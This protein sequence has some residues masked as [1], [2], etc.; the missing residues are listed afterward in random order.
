MPKAHHSKLVSFSI[1]NRN[2]LLPLIFCSK[3]CKELDKMGFETVWYSR[4]R[5]YGQGSRQ[6][7]ACSNRHGLIRKYNLN[8]RYHSRFFVRVG[9]ET[10]YASSGYKHFFTKSCH[11]QTY[12]NY[13]GPSIKTVLTPYLCTG[14]KEVL[15]N[16]DRSDDDMIY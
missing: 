1:S 3:Q 16:F 14:F 13:Y 11:R 2:P 4:P 12:Q 9:H 10:M 5:K 7:R 8:I 6:C 15:N